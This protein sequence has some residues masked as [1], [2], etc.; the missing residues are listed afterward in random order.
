MARIA[1][2]CT[3]TAGGSNPVAAHVTDPVAASV[4][5]IAA[6]AAVTSDI[7]A[8]L[9]VPAISGDAPSTTAVTLIQTD[10]NTLKTALAPG[11]ASTV[12][13]SF[14]AAAVVTKNKLRDCV[15]AIMR[16]IDGSNDL[17]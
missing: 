1:V 12:V 7:T 5:G 9:A 15:A 4:A 3:L 14:D 8:A 2:V 16:V 13:L 11:T 17:T 10:F 6:E